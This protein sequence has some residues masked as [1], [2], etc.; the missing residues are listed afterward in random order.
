MGVIGSLNWTCREAAPT[1]TCMRP[2]LFALVALSTLTLDAREVRAA[3]TTT[4]PVIDGR[5]DEAAWQTAPV[6][7]GFQ[8]QRPDNGAAS[9]QPTEV[10]LLY[11]EDALYVGARLHDRKPVTRI[12]GR[13]DTFLDS[14]WIGILLDPLY[15][16]RSGNAFFV[17]PDGV[18]YDEVISDD[19]SEDTNWDGVWQSATAIGEDGWSAEM[20]IPFSQLR[21]READ[22]QVWGI[23]F[24][25]WI[26]TNQEQARLISHPRNVRGFASK[27]GT[28]TGL[29]GVKPRPRI[30]LTPYAVSVAEQSQLVRE[31][32]PLNRDR[33]TRVDGGFD[34]RWTS[35]SNLTFAATLNP[36]FGQVEV[37][38]AILNLSQFELFLP[39]KRP[40]FVDGAK[41]FTFGGIAS[42]PVSPFRIAHP[43]IFYSRR[44]GRVPQGN[45]RVVSEYVDLP[46]ETTIRGAAKVVGRAGSTGF[47]ALGA[48]TGAEEAR[49]AAGTVRGERTVE[50]QTAYLASRVTRDL[51]E[52]SRVGLIVTSAL[53][54]TDADTRFLP[55][56]SLVAGTDGYVWFRKR[57]VLL[58]WL[59]AS[60]SVHGD[61]EAI[62]AL[63]RSP[64]HSYQRVDATHLHVDPTRRSF[65][66]WGGKLALSR[67]S[68][69]WRYQLLTE[70]YSPG[71]EINDLGFQT[72]ADIRA[73]HATA[74][75][76]DVATRKRT[77]NNRVTV[78]RYFL[79]NQA[80]ERLGSGFA[81][82]TATTFKNYMT[83]AAR[84]SYSLEAFDDREARGGPLVRKPRGWTGQVI[85][86]T[87][88]RKRVSVSS[89]YSFGGDDDGG[90]TSVLS[91]TTTLRPRPNINVSVATIATN[92]VVASKWFSTA[93]GRY[94]FGRLE[95]RRLEI[96]PRVDWTIRRNLTLQL[97]LQPL[98]AS[99]TYDDLRELRA[100]ST[101]SPL[102]GPVANPDFVFRSMRAN[103]VLRWEIGGASTLFVVWNE[104]RSDRR[105]ATSTGTFDDFR[106]VDDVP[107][108]N[109][110]MLKVS[111]RFDLPR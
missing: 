37:D 12:L 102:S 86:G 40:F 91:L 72:R 36:D 98:A 59:L 17:N 6:I 83:L 110:L 52:R 67:E 80:G 71:F 58:D 4:P 14:D 8:Q 26:R 35:R 105:L 64:S 89:S 51:G 84:G 76:F 81:G 111:H 103:G 68:G 15:D 5:V 99:G 21:F 7:T 100:D 92:N 19:D 78:G 27:F 90:S 109:R 87:D 74:T 46:D 23:N 57:T 39:E 10:W 24:I 11:D 97:Y 88:T 31:T 54:D 1:L 30:E 41:L 18:Q 2:F 44:I 95:D 42:E 9:S 43:L 104:G 73:A 69:T 25:R 75:Y 45:G 22:R 108:E 96:A 63:Q 48:Y 65:D 94:L 60:S 32:D 93:G 13:R 3:R 20:R 66:G 53:R 16:R 77:R 55:D 70:S 29:D 85:V 33:S 47:T 38:P 79:W 101:Y 50:P 56:R 49:F 106:A 82:D 28:L 107:A 62:T 61:E 34:L